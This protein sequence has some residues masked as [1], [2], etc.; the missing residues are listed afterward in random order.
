MKVFYSVAQKLKTMKLIANYLINTAAIGIFSIFGTFFMFSTSLQAQSTAAAQSEPTLLQRIAEQD[1]RLASLRNGADAAS[2]LYALEKAQC[3]LDFSRHEALRNNP[4]RVPEAAYAKGAAIAQA[5]QSQVPL[6][7]AMLDSQ[8]LANRTDATNSLLVAPMR[9]DL[10]QQFDAIKA[11]RGMACSAKAVACGE[12]MLVQ[13]AHAHERIDWR[14]AQ[15]YF[16]MAEDFAR[17]AKQN[18]QACK[19]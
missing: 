11:S 1:K 13:A 2:S 16:G 17:E 9:K 15:P 12:V 8:L 19:P 3:W 14:Y 18:A 5:L 7:P 6:Q 10:A 4:S